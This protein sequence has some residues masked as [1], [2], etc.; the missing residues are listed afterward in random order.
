MP[1]CAQ[2]ENYIEIKIKQ[3]IMSIDLTN[4][5]NDGINYLKEWRNRYS[6]SEYLSKIVL[7]TFYRQ[8]AMDYIWDSQIINS[9]ESFSNTESQ[10]LKAYQKLEFEYSKSAENFILDNRLESLIKEGME[11]GGL[12]YNTSLPLILQAEK[13]NNKVV[14]ELEFT[15]LYWL[16]ANKSILMWA[17]FGRIGYNYL[18]SVTKVTNAIIKMNEPFTYKNSL[19]IFGQLIVSNFMDTKYVPLKPLYYE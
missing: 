4:P 9:F 14:E 10:I 7:N 19:N 17:S 15:Y 12:N 5:L 18:E 6:K 16:L 11:I 13:G 1:S 3:N 8:Y 2:F